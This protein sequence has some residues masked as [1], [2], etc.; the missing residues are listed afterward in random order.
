MLIETAKVRALCTSHIAFRK[1]NCF[2]G[3]PTP[4]SS[5]A[6]DMPDVKADR[7]HTRYLG[8]GMLVSRPCVDPRDGHGTPMLDW[9]KMRQCVARSLI[10]FEVNKYVSANDFT[11]LSGTDECVSVQISF[12]GISLRTMALGAPL[13]GQLMRIPNIDPRTRAP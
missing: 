3:F 8:S 10:Y 6:R 2:L 13:S 7:L 1:A 5:R 11:T 4:V 12:Q 9:H